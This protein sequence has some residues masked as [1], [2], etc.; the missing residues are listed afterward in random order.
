MLFH[1][2]I[3]TLTFSI[4]RSLTHVQRQKNGRS[5][6][7]I[8]IVANWTI[9]SRK[10][11]T[12]QCDNS[13]LYDRKINLLKK[14]HFFSD[15]SILSKV[16]IFLQFGVKTQNK[17]SF[18]VQNI[19]FVPLFCLNFNDKQNNFITFFSHC[20]PIISFYRI[21]WQNTTAKCASVCVYETANV[22]MPE[23][24]CEFFLLLLNWSN[25]YVTQIEFLRSQKRRGWKKIR[26]EKENTVHRFSSSPI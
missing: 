14:Y 3:H 9:W 25:S 20:T 12:R 19:H 22:R 16:Q 10:K 11:Y 1:P 2:H 18:S 7:S 13:K 15:E 21:W 17:F 4:A 6:L 8:L 24:V 23:C 5:S 26:R